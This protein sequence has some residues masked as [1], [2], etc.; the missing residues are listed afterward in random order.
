M[1]IPQACVDNGD[2]IVNRHMEGSCHGELSEH[3]IDTA[4]SDIY[5]CCLLAT[6]ILGVVC[7]CDISWL[8]QS[9]LGHHPA[10][11]P[12]YRSLREVIVLFIILSPE[13]CY[14]TAW[15]MVGN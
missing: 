14:R 2:A 15:H 3:A 10:S 13:P 1:S 7:Y 12:V 9:L 4:V 11:L 5:L 6:E 8:I